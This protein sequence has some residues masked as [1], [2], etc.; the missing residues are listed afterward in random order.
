MDKMGENQRLLGAQYDRQSARSLN[1]LYSICSR[2]QCLPTRY[3]LA[4][5]GFLGFYCHIAMC[6][7]L[8]IAIVAMTNGTVNS[9]SNENFTAEC[10]KYNVSEIQVNC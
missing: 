6:A 7:N 4:L 9:D 8:S 3:T 10:P 2:C 5:L 1:C